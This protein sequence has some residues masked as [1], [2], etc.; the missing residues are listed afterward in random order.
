MTPEAHETNSETSPE[1]TMGA[2]EPAPLTPEQVAEL[3]AK[4]AKADENWERCL[5]ATADLD[6]Y[7]K[8]AARERQD[9]IRYA[10]EELLE[11]LIPVLDNFEMAVQAAQAPQGGSLEAIRTGVQM[12]HTQ[13]K[14][15]L[16]EAGLEDLN[17]AGQVFDPA[18]QEAVS[19][20]ETTEVADGHVLQ[21][22]RKGY[23]LRD[24]L[25][26]P[27]TVIVARKPSA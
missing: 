22:L 18:T 25:V 20:Q 7:R 14:A 10:N 13:F 21:Q 17:V 16:A 3:Q 4:A 12:I 27:A 8:R 6:N 5:R 23:R 26:R 1:S 2:G 11:K 9:A 24:R 15:V 19:Q